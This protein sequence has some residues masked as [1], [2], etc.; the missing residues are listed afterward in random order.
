MITEIAE[1]EVKAGSEEAFIA[2][3]ESV[4]SVFHRAP[5]CHG[6]ELQRS[7][8]H[9]QL[10]LL[11]VQWE[12][13]AHHTEQFRNSPD[14]ELWRQAVGSYFAASPKVQHASVVVS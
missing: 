9:P 11:L 14:F 10:F 6:V 8:E 3:V 4:K 5:G 13:V 2:G 12:T 1:I 7:I